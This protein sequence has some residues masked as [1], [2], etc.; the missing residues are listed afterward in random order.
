VIPETC[1]DRAS[2][3]VAAISHRRLWR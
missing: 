1:I 2:Y 3:F